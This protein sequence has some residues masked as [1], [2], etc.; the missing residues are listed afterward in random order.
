MLHVIY[1]C[2]LP[3]SDINYTQTKSRLTVYDV[4]QA[5]QQKKFL[6]NVNVEN[7]ITCRV[8]ACKII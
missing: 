4:Y 2:S 7:P 6:H 8:V 3:W 5:F 1:D